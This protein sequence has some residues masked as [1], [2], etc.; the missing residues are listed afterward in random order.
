MARWMDPTPE[1]EAA[2]KKWTA[3]RPPGVRELAE[4]FDPWELY[5]LA[6]D[7]GERPNKVTIAGFSA[8]GGHRHCHAPGHSH[9][10][11]NQKPA[12]RVRVLGYFNAVGFQREVIVE[13]ENLTPCELP[14]D[15]EL[16][17]SADLSEEELN[18]PA[19]ERRAIMAARRDRLRPFREIKGMLAQY[20]EEGRL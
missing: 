19:E 18:R 13:P 9:H 12:V 7:D 10:H 3:E 2:Y 17:G 11:E 16:V 5:A 4:K 8:A 1:R 6:R 20:V 14:A 15:D